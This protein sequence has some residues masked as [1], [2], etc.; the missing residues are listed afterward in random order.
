MH[1]IPFYPDSVP[2][3]LEHGDLLQPY[4]LKWRHGVSEL[5]MASLYP[6]TKKRNYTVSRYENTQGESHF[7]F[8]GQQTQNEV[9]ED[10]AFLPG[11]YP[12]PYMVEKLFSHIAEI[13]TISEQSAPIWKAEIEANHPKLIIGEDRDN[14]DYLYERKSLVDLVG[15]SLHKK[16]AHVLH[17]VEDHPDRVLIPAELA[18]PHDMV[19]VLDGWA[20]GRDVI[21][22][23]NATLLAIE[24]LRNLNL[25]GAVLYAGNTPVAFTLGEYDGCTRFIIHIEKA[26]PDVRGVYQYINRAFAASLP[27]SVKTVNREQD[28][29][30]PGLR[31]AKLTYKPASFGMKYRIRAQ[32]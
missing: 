21:E 2:L 30:I 29:G 28:L 6:F 3:T 27:D 11:G 31:Q 4:L 25:K 14:A 5:S 19:Q 18:N 13:N 10:Y 8:I 20:K 22:D 26:I 23:Y 15:Q 12:G 7:L 17:F 1:S 16:L 9:M 32:A 24:Q